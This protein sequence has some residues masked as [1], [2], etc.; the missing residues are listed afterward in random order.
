[1]DIGI[2]KFKYQPA[3]KPD[4]D[5]RGQGAELQLFRR[6]KVW[7]WLALLPFLAS[8]CCTALTIDAGTHAHRFDEVHRIERAGITTN[9]EIVILALGRTAERSR[10]RPL[11]ITQVLPSEEQLIWTSTN[12]IADGW[13]PGRNILAHAAEITIGPALVNPTNVLA[14]GREPLNGPSA[15]ETLCLVRDSNPD[16]HP[17]YLLY[18]SRTQRRIEIILDGRDV[19]APS[20]Y[21]LLLITPVTL[22]TDIAFFPVEAI[23]VATMI[24][25]KTSPKTM[26]IPDPG[27]H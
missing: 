7:S 18:T 12:N 27:S 11:T 14:A 26:L 22:A 4:F 1:M 8:G 10:E 20:H 3:D 23:W 17:Y 25:D 5:T 15:G 13:E 6:C 21:P 24:G 16:D 9:N 19:D 2:K